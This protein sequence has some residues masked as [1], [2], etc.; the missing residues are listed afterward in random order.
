[1]KRW[2]WLV[3]LLFVMVGCDQEST[4]KAVDAEPTPDMAMV[5]AD[6]AVEVDMDPGDEPDAAPLEPDMFVD[7]GPCQGLTVIDF[8]ADATE[9]DGLYTVAAAATEESNNALQPQ[10]AC[11]GMNDT[12][13]E[14]AFNFVAPSAGTWIVFTSNPGEN[15]DT[16]MYARRTCDDAATEIACN[17]DI[18]WPRLR[19]SS[20]R[21]DLEEGEAVYVIVDAFFGG[22]A[23]AGGFF[24]LNARLL[25][26]VDPGSDCDPDGLVNACTEE[27]FCRLDDPEAEEL[28]TG[29]CTP[30]TPPVSTETIAYKV[31]E[32]ILAAKIT[33]TDLSRDVTEGLLQLY[34]GEERL[35]LDEEQG[36]DTFII[37]PS[38]PVYGQEEVVFKYRR[39][40]LADYPQTTAVRLQLRDSRNNTSEW[41][42]VELEAPPPAEAE[43]ACDPDRILD[44]CVEGFACLD[45][46]ED[47]AFTCSEVTAPTFVAGEAWHNPMASTLG[48]EAMGIDPD[49]DV[50]GAFLELID[51]A[52]E[53][54][55]SGT[56]EF[57]DLVQEDG[58]Y[59]GYFSFNVR[60]DLEYTAIRVTVR[61]SEGL[62]SEPMVLQLGEPSTVEADDPCDVLNARTL[63]PEGTVC[64]APDEE[65]PA[66]CG[67]PPTTCPEAWGEIP[68]VNDHGESPEWRYNGSNEGAEDFSRG[69]C[70]GGAGQ[71]VLVFT[72]PE[73]GAYSFITDGADGADTVLSARSHCGLSG[74]EYPDLELACNDD[75]GRGEPLSLVRLDLEADQVVYIVVDG[76]VDND[77]AAWNGAYTLVGR[78]QN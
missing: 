66:T 35:I 5:E 32:T 19:T 61:D 31:G 21:L 77:G 40:V 70:G 16:M 34:N 64:Y 15:Y 44:N 58:N 41:V 18:D 63:C 4:S 7:L 23:V 1:M 10:E 45:R 27:H 51:D 33:G 78:K 73:T 56:F 55:A 36:F 8:F 68:S 71:E 52:E 60:D 72:A 11:R 2:T 9:A 13:N 50:V 37:Q 54:I 39:P 67:E 59:T 22:D 3:A 75:L 25:E 30:D 6:M 20:I 47:E 62:E 53:R 43:A 74:V 76:F 12:G 17:D 38:E 24:D 29:V 14:A 46:D 69:S 28:G 48:V 57:R 49:G 42:R 26:V 65:T